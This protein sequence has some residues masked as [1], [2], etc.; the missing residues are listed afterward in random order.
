MNLNVFL[1]FVL[2]ALPL[3]LLAIGD[4]TPTVDAYSP[5]SVVSVEVT[6]LSTPIVVQPVS[7]MV[8][9]EFCSSGS[10]GEAK[11]RWRLGS[12]VRKIR[13]ARASRGRVRIFN[14]RGVRF[15]GRV[16]GRRRGY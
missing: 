5:P 16:F 9:A 11:G 13:E 3:Y 14:G 12:G 1:V 4:E 6:D 7:V 15:L 8:T 10:C 2:V